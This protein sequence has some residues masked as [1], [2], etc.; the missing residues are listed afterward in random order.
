MG[1]GVGGKLLFCFRGGVV[2]SEARAKAIKGNA[3]VSSAPSSTVTR[4]QVPFD[5]VGLKVNGAPGFPFTFYPT[6][7]LV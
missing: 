3:L 6:G 4:K 7:R 2:E 1:G 5:L